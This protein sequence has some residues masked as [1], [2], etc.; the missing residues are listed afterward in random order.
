MLP[1]SH[2][3]HS[4]RMP[5]RER[6]KETNAW[7][8]LHVFLSEKNDRKRLSFYNCFII[9]CGRT[10]TPNH[11]SSMSPFH[12]CIQSRSFTSSS[13]LTPHL[14]PTPPPAPP[15]T[16]TTMTVMM[17][18]IMMMMVM[19]GLRQREM[20]EGSKVKLE[21]ICVRQKTGYMSS[22]L[23]GV[24]GVFR[25]IFGIQGIWNLRIKPIRSKA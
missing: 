5:G 12:R 18:M 4:N 6:V 8:S 24:G 23:L 21:R 16:M 22:K 19:K 17:M 10:I 2:G 9:S 7:K 14:R 3:C 11:R 13:E 15:M 25:N 1:L 20:V